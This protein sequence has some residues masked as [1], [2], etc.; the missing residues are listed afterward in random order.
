MSAVPPAQRKRQV[1]S[2]IADCVTSVTD[3]SAREIR[4]RLE[5]QAQHLKLPSGTEIEVDRQGSLVN[6]SVS[7]VQEIK[8][9]FYVYPW[10]V[11]IS[12][13]ESGF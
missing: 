13:Q 10:A 2:S 11:N 1:Q 8:L 5:E 3:I 4:Q 7:Y 6:A 9:P 12:V